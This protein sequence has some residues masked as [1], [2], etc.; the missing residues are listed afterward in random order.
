MPLNMSRARFFAQIYTHDPNDAGEEKIIKAHL[1]IELNIAWVLLTRGDNS[2]F[3]FL[4]KD[5]NVQALV[6]D[7]YG[8]HGVG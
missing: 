1:L 3:N 6:R 2:Y 5:G 8:F 7:Q 4:R